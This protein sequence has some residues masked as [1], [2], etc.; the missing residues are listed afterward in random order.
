MKA[1]DD[2]QGLG[3]DEWNSPRQVQKE[4]DMDER[5]IRAAS[6]ALGY[7]VDEERITQ[8]IAAHQGEDTKT[9]RQHLRERV[10]EFDASGGR[11]VEL[12]E[13]I[14]GL[15]IALAARRIIEGNRER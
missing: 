8:A 7:E 10:A 12:A 15:K 1:L 3:E 2:A 14:D 11:G 5:I 6:N 13:E 4:K 9:L